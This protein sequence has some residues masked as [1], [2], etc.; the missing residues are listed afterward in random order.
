MEYI[1]FIVIKMI[2]YLYIVVLI[3][4]VVVIMTSAQYYFPKHTKK[5][6]KIISFPVRS[7]VNWIYTDSD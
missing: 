5:V 2:I 6:S 4:F 1:N 3:I 7:V